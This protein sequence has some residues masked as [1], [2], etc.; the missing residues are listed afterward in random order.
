MKLAACSIAVLVLMMIATAGAL[1]QVPAG[2]VGDSSLRAFLP[3]FEE[4]TSRFINGDPALWKQKASR[5]DDAT[6]MGA[7][8]GYEK[9]WNE[10]GPRYEWAAARLRESGAKV[11]VDTLPL[12][13]VE[14]SATPW[15]SS[16]VSCVGPI[17]T[18]QRRWLCG[19]RTSSGRK[20]AFLDSCIITRIHLLARR[21]PPRSRTSN[22]ESDAQRCPQT[23]GHLCGSALSGNLNMRIVDE[24]ER[25]VP[26]ALHRG[27]GSSVH[28]ARPIPPGAWPGFPLVLRAAL[29]QSHR[30][31]FRPGRYR[32]VG[33]ALGARAHRR[34]P[35]RREAP[36]GSNFAANLAVGVS[37]G[38]PL[39]LYMREQRLERSTRVSMGSGA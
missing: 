16:E 26:G 8:G 30:W 12:E 10:V 38:L 13:S 23:G 1:S 39:F 11:K 36:L 29:L 21:T 19:S 31:L 34:S 14:I 20:T 28:A 5:R 37:L 9:G 33:G 32:V 6:I 35:R 7:W 15:R 27:H 18:S 2:A 17:R 25:A 3:E 22:T 4:A 24:T